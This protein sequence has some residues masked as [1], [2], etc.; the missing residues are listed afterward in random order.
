MKNAI[1]LLFEELDGGVINIVNEDIFVPVMKEV[2]NDYI[3]EENFELA[4]RG[5]QLIKDADS[6]RVIFE[7]IKDKP[8]LTDEVG[9]GGMVEL[10]EQENFSFDVLLTACN[11][12]ELREAVVYYESQGYMSSDKV[13]K[14]YQ[15]L[16][17]ANAL[18]DFGKRVANSYFE[19]QK[20]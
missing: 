13:I 19:I 8:I 20:K 6:I 9:I 17:D 11:E 16:G 10:L 7:A 2:I 12:S 4:Y 1:K 18:M 5:S 14:I 15:K 3:D